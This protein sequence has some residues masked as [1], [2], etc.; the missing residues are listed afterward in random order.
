MTRTE[1]PERRE[2]R[3]E[4]TGGTLPVNHG[5]WLLVPAP[6]GGTF[7]RYEV[8]AET[9]LPVPGW[10]ERA[11]LRDS[12]PVVLRRVAERVRELE[13]TEPSYFEGVR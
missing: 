1:T 6:G 13:R 3:W 11:I 12:L 5:R 10:M 9:G 7:A 4:R 2:E 8:D